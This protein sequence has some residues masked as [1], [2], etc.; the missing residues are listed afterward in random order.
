MIKVY[1]ISNCDTV[2]KARNFLDENFIDY[3]FIDFKKIPP[4]VDQ[5]LKWSDFFGEL[6]V[7]KN[8]TTYRKLKDEFESMNEI[9]KLTFIV[10]NSSMIKRPIFEKNSKVLFAGFEETKLKELFL[11]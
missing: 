6:P 7:N 4:T 2:K 9:G 1:G 11:E 5:V 10:Q 8:G 3:K